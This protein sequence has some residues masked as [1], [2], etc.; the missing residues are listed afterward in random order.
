M[1]AKSDF[2]TNSSS[3]SYIITCPQNLGIEKGSIVYKFISTLVE[4]FDI[5]TNIEELK[6]FWNYRGSD[7]EDDDYKKCVEAI[8]N[9]GC[10]ISASFEYGSELDFPNEF[11][12]KFG[13]EIISGD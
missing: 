3:T 4:G 1:K 8:D 12:S 2:V 9:G 6:K 10:V 13:G 7:E 11:I 5:A